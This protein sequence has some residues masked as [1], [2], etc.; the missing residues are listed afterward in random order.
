MGHTETSRT[1][2][3]R[4]LHL[5]RAGMI[6]ALGLVRAAGPADAAEAP[7]SARAYDR[8]GIP[9]VVPRLELHANPFG[10]VG[11]FLPGGP[12]DTASH[13]FFRPL[14]TNGRSCATCHQP[15][16]GMS[17]SLRN[18]RA[19]FKATAGTDPL[20][21]PID[22]ANCPSALP[23]KR[24]ALE[25]AHALLLDRAVIRIPLP[26]PPQD[27][28][29]N[30]KRVEFDL[31]ITP[32]MDA[33]GCNTDPDHGLAAGFVSVYR[34]PPMTAQMNFKTLRLDGTGPILRG[35]LMWD[36]RATSLERQA[37]DATRSHAQADRDPSA[38]EV[39]EIVG[40]QNAIFN[41]Q[42]ADEAAGRLDAAG[43]AG[44]PVNLQAQ[45]PLPAFGITFDEYQGWSGRSGR[46]LAIS[47]GQA[48]FNGRPFTVQGVAG[49]NDLPGMGNPATA[50]CSTCHNVAH[51]GSDLLANPQRDIGVGG[52]GRRVGGPEPARDL[53]R[54]T[55]TC[56]ADAR[57]H[58][59]LGRG[60]IV[61][62]D[63]GLALVTGKCADIGRFTIPQLRALA[64]REPYFH[65]GSAGTLR[66]V[67]EFYDR[68]FGIGLSA[69]DRQDLANFLAAL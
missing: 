42:L 10:A 56:R 26:W 68:R 64:A 11:A 35:S 62:N 59:F 5:S 23:G 27:R 2:R 41:A 39:A 66:E 57:P 32:R 69:R 20:F 12:V 53:P 7:P 31:A 47:R 13:A 24:R 28:K 34:R 44:G 40:F 19:R 33:P 14:G 30:A 54:F 49:F 46:R 65:D 61:T 58:P 3:R 4:A 25:D 16:S 6:V 17:I 36:G 48:I 29:G 55:L 63:P 37:I 22:G 52:T 9:A 21:A 18:V 8:G 1:A 50:T 43:A 38:K 67:V 15:P 51:G 45:L 60:P